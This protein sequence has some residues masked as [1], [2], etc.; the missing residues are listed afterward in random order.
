MPQ[1][2]GGEERLRDCPT[3]DQDDSCDAPL[4]ISCWNSSP[5]SSQP[6]P[7]LTLT[8]HTSTT[9]ATHP[10][11]PATSPAF[12]SLQLPSSKSTHNSSSST[13]SLKLFLA[14]STLSV[15][16]GC[17]RER[18]GESWQ[19]LVYSGLA[20]VAVGAVTTATLSLSIFLIHGNRN[21]KSSFSKCLFTVF[22]FKSS[23]LLGDEVGHEAIERNPAYQ[24]RAS[25]IP[26][27]SNTA[28]AGIHTLS[29]QSTAHVYEDVV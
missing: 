1:C 29:P 24:T 16:T 18:G 12:S 25:L 19:L 14:S 22:E 15:P 21:R 23:G 10:L 28:Y 11:S 7:T 17:A 9:T 5:V 13:I 2:E 4:V 26:S 6:S 27:S 20:G 8:T 3:V